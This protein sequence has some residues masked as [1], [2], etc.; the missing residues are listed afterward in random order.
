MTINKNQKDNGFALPEIFLIVIIVI[1][2]AVIG[3]L[4]YKNNHKTNNSNSIS[5]TTSSNTNSSV[6]AGN[7]LYTD[8]TNGY[9]VLLPNSWEY[10]DIKTTGTSIT[11]P[12]FE[13]TAVQNS[14]NQA[15]AA[16]DGIFIA[17]DT[18][19]LAPKDYFQQNGEG[20]AGGVIT[21]NTD[22]INGYTAY[23]ANMSQQGATYIVTTL[24]DK[25]KVV[26]FEYYLD[27]PYLSMAQQIIQSI[28]FL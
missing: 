1:L 28:K 8:K 11:Q 18:S 6:S 2:L 14:S 24:T 5:T 25:G 9:S 7:K 3:W 15:N 10:I 16:I 22:P 4:V 23:T 12:A 20:R 21:D 17:T 13:P 27:N 19:N 26:E